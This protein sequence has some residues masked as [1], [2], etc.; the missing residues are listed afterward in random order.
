[1][2]TQQRALLVALFFGI[3]GALSIIAAS[4][5]FA[6]LDLDSH[7]YLNFAPSRTAIYP[8]F[9]SL[10]SGLSYQIEII[11]ILQAALYSLS[12]GYL[13]YILHLTMRSWFI[14]VLFGLG[15][16]GNMYLQAFNSVILTESLTFTL[17]HILIA[18]VL[19]ALYQPEAKPY[20]ATIFIGV[21]GGLLAALKPA[22]ITMLPALMIIIG[23]IAYQHRQRM[24]RHLG[25]YGLAFLA[26]LLGESMAYY[27]THEARVS[28]LPVTL[29]GKA[30]ILTTAP[31]FQIPSSLSVD[32]AAILHATDNL[33]DPYQSWL[34][35]ETNP[36]VRSNIRGNIEVFGQWETLP[37]VEEREGL[38][39][40]SDDMLA[41]IGR[42]VIVEHKMAYIRLSLSYLSE[43]WAVQSLA[44]S[45]KIF[46]SIL[47]IFEDAPLN[48]A[49][50][51]FTAKGGPL[52]PESGHFANWLSV[53]IFPAFALLG[54]ISLIGGLVS[55]S[56][57]LAGGSRGSGGSKRPLTDM[58]MLAALHIIG[59]SNL[60]FIA[61]VNIPTPRYLMPHFAGFVLAALIGVTLLMR[62]LKT[63]T[64]DKAQN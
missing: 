49:L 43:L 50:P 40:P 1:M 34:E 17:M 54:L 57:I 24:G 41:A 13:I 19:K 8:L 30:A 44:F 21:I 52:D 7:S 28:L 39:R 10:F 12:L 33:L 9:L 64:D 11:L 59:W 62:V 4:P 45:H 58:V 56:V 51:T 15:V 14:T 5:L 31:Q 55:V 36:L 42:A 23:L 63:H 38:P 27:Q 25:I 29:F 6:P 61:L 22:M 16:A 53:I 48:N 26:P 32:E 3:L 60:I 37:L 46:G 47:P 20:R 18:F 2:N 35:K